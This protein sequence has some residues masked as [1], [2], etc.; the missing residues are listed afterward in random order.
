VKNKDGNNK[1]NQRNATKETM[2]MKTL[3]LTEEDNWRKLETVSEYI[4]C[5]GVRLIEWWFSSDYSKVE[6][7]TSGMKISVTIPSLKVKIDCLKKEQ[8]HKYQTLNLKINEEKLIVWGKE[9]AMRDTV[10]C[11]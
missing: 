5:F 11:Q 7:I 3:N 8:P 2:L 4:Q 1:R 6:V 10:T 9:G